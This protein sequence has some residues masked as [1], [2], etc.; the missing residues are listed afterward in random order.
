MLDVIVVGGGL[1]GLVSALHLKQ[2]GLEVSVVEMKNY[3]FHKVCGEYISNE[4]LAYLESLGLDIPGLQPR[5]MKRFQISSPSGKSLETI[6]P[7]GGFSIRRY[8]LDNQLYELAKK[9]GASFYLNTRVEDVQF[10]SDHFDIYCQGGKT[11]KARIAI[12]SY[13]KRSLL[14][15]KFNRSF[16]KDRSYYVGV[17]NYYAGDFPDDLVAIHNFAG[18]YCGLSEV[19][20]GLV[21]VAYLT[22]KNSL[23]K[24]GSLEKLEQK[25]LRANPY[26]DQFFKTSKPIWQKPLVI[27]NVSF[28]P[29]TLLERDVLMCGDA[30]GM[31]PPICG[32][33]M[34][35][36]IHSAKIL[37]E[38]LT[39][40]FLGKR[41]FAELRQAYQQQWKAQFQNRL[42]WGRQIQRMLNKPMI[43]EWAIRSLKLAPALLPLIIKQTHG[44]P[45]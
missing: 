42:F 25:A 36:A 4:V 37:S 6:L 26:L 17:K 40:F 23:Q 8:T 38:L 14:D 30:A 27:S 34:A 43:S 5:W 16:F 1:A 39:D 19:E 35:M 21:N 44:K 29:K 12:G 11:L 2:T 3:P 24:F 32:N 41:N 33:G 15:R 7:L 13:G 10:Q 22:S 28:D 9:K 18:G 45:I 20:N 31:I